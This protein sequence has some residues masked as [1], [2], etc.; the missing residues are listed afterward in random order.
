MRTM[1]R[2]FI[3]DDHAI[4]RDVLR[5]QLQRAEIDVVGEAGDLDD[6]LRQARRLHPEI[7]V[8]DAVLPQTH[9]LTALTLLRGAV[10]DAQILYLGAYADPL[11]VNAA[12]EAGAS[13]YVFKDDAGTETV[14]TVLALA[15]ARAGNHRGAPLGHDRRVVEPPSPAKV[16]S[17]SRARVGESPSRR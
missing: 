6:G 12:H 7:I 9:G 13:A 8:L 14:P 11:H 5:R 2:V 15:G 4:V 16:T 10:P 17:S 3:I 1:T